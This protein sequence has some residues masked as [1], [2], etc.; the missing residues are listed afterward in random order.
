MEVTYSSR[1][2]NMFIFS[3][4]LH[5]FMQTNTHSFINAVMAR[6]KSQRKK[7]SSR[8][9]RNASLSNFSRAL[10]RLKKMNANRQHEAMSM[11]NAA[12]IRQFC[13][14]LKKLKYAKLPAKSKKILRKHRKEVKKLLSARTGLSKRRKM[15]TQS[16]GG[17][18]KALLSSI[19]IVGTV[20]NLVD[21]V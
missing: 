13:K 12:F 3:F 6:R 14:Q 9:K 16:G 11:A 19:P 17:F 20:M 7:K 5:D 10:L 4:P 15:L 1:M 21:N 8:R 18:L 2:L